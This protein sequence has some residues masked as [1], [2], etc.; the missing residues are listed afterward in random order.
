MED[1]IGRR[2]DRLEQN[3]FM[4]DRASLI[5]PILGNFDF[6]FLQYTDNYTF[7]SY[8]IEKEKLE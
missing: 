7:C 8:L 1:L 2:K 5:V 6:L 4:F 3:L